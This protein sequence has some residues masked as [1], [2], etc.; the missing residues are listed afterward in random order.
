MKKAATSRAHPTFWPLQCHFPN[1]NGDD[2]IHASGPLISDHFFPRRASTAGFCNFGSR[3]ENVKCA[4]S[5]QP[6]YS[7]WQQLFNYVLVD[8]RLSQRN[9]NP[10]SIQ[11]SSAVRI[12][13]RH[14]SALVVLKHCA[15]AGS[16]W[17]AKAAW[18]SSLK[19]RKCKF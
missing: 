12:Y 9:A 19:F 2:F 6:A 17:T 11:R 16:W 7:H 15:Q 1:R 4:L 3:Q 13:M 8:R 10:R 18:I 5:E 14:P